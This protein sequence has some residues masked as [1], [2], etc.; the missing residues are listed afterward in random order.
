M[1]AIRSYY[2]TQAI[3][4][5]IVQPGVLVG[6]A[7]FPYDPNFDSFWISPDGSKVLLCK[8]GRNIFLYGL[9][10]DDFGREAVV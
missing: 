9:D 5:G 6:K 1:Y 4:S 8:D 10:P 7:P 2:V 3:Y